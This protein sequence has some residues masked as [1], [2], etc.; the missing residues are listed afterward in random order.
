MLCIA[1]SKN[2][3]GRDAPIHCFSVPI[4]YLP[5][6]ITANTN[7][8]QNQYLPILIPAKTDTCQ[9]QCLSKTNTCQYRY[10]P[11]PANTNTCQKPMILIP[12][13]EFGYL[14]IPILIPIPELF[15]LDNN[16]SLLV[17]LLLLLVVFCVTLH[18][19]IVNHTACIIKRARNTQMHTQMQF[20]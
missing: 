5:K 14:P 3:G 10:L 15:F 6:L 16:W 12:I 1:N 13:P 17:L 11:I 8:Y 19:A 7:T 2:I 20:I 9:N 18:E 4:Q